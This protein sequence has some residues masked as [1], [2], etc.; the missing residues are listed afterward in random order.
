MK[1]GHLFRGLLLG[2][3]LATA[4]AIS[5]SAQ[6]TDAQKTAID[7]IA[8]KVLADTGI[9]AASVAVVKDGKLALAQAYGDAKLN[10]RVAATPE[11]RFKIASNSKQIAAAAILLLAERHKLS[12][13][14]PVSRWLPDLTRAHEVTIRELLAHTSGYQDYFPLDFVNELMSKET[15]PQKILDGWAKKPLDFDPGTK[16][17]YSNTN[18]VIAGQIIEKIT[19]RPVIEFL[20]ANILKPLG[21]TSAVDDSAGNWTA[22]DPSG[23]QTFALGPARPAVPEGNGWM[24]AAGELAMTASDLARWDISLINGTILKPE[25]L[26]EL[27]TE[28]LLKN[29]TGTRYA[30]G[31]DVDRDGHGHRRWAHGGE[32]SGFISQNVTLPDDKIAIAVLTNGQG[33]A[34]PLIERRIEDM[35]LAETA[36]PEGKIALERAKS[37]FAGLQKGQLD[38]SLLNEDAIFY[39]T[40]QAVADFAASLGPLGA[41]TSFT[42]SGHQGRGGMMERSFLIQA[43][44]KRMSLTTY[45]MPDGKFAQY[46]VD[47]APTAQ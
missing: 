29:G 41:P 3:L 8:R 26:K 18:Y 1:T 47:P 2:C 9:P 7:Q 45:I 36:D 12:L 28:V 15:T 11:M 32:A 22:A 38:R 37:L 46:M 13:N 34:A 5:C 19:H 21:M 40:D 6:L 24:Y 20:Q 27:S 10:P 42:E 39:F 33:R 16:W 44:G 17:Q 14:D 31:L 30:L 4:G 43:G 35:L 25:S 23:F